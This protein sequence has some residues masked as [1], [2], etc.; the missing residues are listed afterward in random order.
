[1]GSELIEHLLDRLRA[2][3]GLPPLSVVAVRLVERA[4]DPDATAEEIAGIIDKDPALAVRL[5]R[6]ANSA[7]LASKRPV[8]TLAQ[9]VVRM[10]FDRLRIMAL[11][12]SLRDAFPLGRIG[13]LDLEAFWHASLYRAL[14]AQSFARH[15]QLCLEGEAFLAGL[16]Q[17]IGLPILVNLRLKSFEEFGE[18][19]FEGLLTWERACCGVDHRRVGEAALTYWRFPEPL[20]QSQRVYGH[21][22]RTPGAPPLAK[23]CE[24]A[25]EA[26]EVIVRDSADLPRILDSSAR[27]FNISVDVVN[28]LLLTTVDR[29]QEIAASFLLNVDREKDLMAVMEKANLA[30]SRI[31]EKLVHDANVVRGRPLPSLE[32]VLQGKDREHIVSNTLQAVVHEIRNPLT[33]VAGFAKRLAGAGDQ[34]EKTAR[35]LQIILQEA[36]RL[37]T[38]LEQITQRPA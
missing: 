20:V 13:P 10:G 4:A 36:R 12:L 37:E 23:V 26:A 3:Y 15:S 24:L 34:N 17:D 16:I 35:Y 7:F 2:G 31:S 30:L 19:S 22:A 14:L 27:A 33:A 8:T 11:S 21:R 5:I 6:L 18:T 28:D 9:A 25:R 1:M 32:E 29:V 38:T